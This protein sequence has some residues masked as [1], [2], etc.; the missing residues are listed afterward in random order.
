MTAVAAVRPHPQPQ[1]LNSTTGRDRE[2]PEKPPTKGELRSETARLA[3]QQGLRLH[4]A[5]TRGLVNRFVATDRQG[6]DEL[7]AWLQF[8]APLRLMHTDPTGN[9]A[10]NSVDRHRARSR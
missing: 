4:P 3:L 7:A 10:S 9:D 6:F 1:Q 8:E 5:Q 2:T